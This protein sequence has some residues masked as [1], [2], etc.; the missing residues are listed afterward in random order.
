MAQRQ[1]AQPAGHDVR[2]P[3]ALLPPVPDVRAAND[4]AAAQPA[5]RQERQNHGEIPVKDRYLRTWAAALPL[6]LLPDK[7][8]AYFD[9][10]FTFGFRGIC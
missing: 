5:L 9:E 4:A 10:K 3:H 8:A 7:T 2:R 6:S 1:R